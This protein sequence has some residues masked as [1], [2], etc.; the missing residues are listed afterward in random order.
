MPKNL[1][2]QTSS[3]PGDQNDKG[4]LIANS[5]AKMSPAEISE[6]LDLQKRFADALKAKQPELKI[7]KSDLDELNDQVKDLLT[8]NL[9]DEQKKE[10]EEALS[11]ATD[12]TTESAAG[13]KQASRP[14]FKGVTAEQEEEMAND[15]LPNEEGDRSLSGDEAEE[16]PAPEAK[17]EEGKKA[18]PKKEGVDGASATPET[19][20]PAASENKAPETGENQDQNQAPAQEGGSPKKQGKDSGGGLDNKMGLPTEAGSEAP[21]KNDQSTKGFRAPTQEDLWGDEM[22]KV[23]RLH[24]GMMDAKKGLEEAKKKIED[25][26]K[27]AST[28]KKVK[29]IYSIYEVAALATAEDIISIVLLFIT[30]NGQLLMSGF[31]FAPGK[32]FFKGFGPKNLKMFVPALNIG[33]FFLMLLMWV[34][35]ITALFMTIGMT[36]VILGGLGMLLIKLGIA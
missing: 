6:N 28:V 35:V 12:S 16:G 18:E 13:S 24:Q 15:S 5:L 9:S 34:L 26:K 8:G 1:G 36:I 23:R 4:A 2:K 14:K 11:Q 21:K 17:G 32:S 33:E 3:F 31:E 30:L 19:G 29:N 25:I 7:D 20:A 22:S 10:L 27:I